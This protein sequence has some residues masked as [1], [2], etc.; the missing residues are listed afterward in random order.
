MTI[1]TTTTLFD[2]ANGIS[3]AYVYEGTYPSGTLV[4]SAPTSTTPSATLDV[5]I[6]G[7]SFAY[8]DP[9]ESFYVLFDLSD[10]NDM[11][12]DTLSAQLDSMVVS[13]GSSSSYT[14][15]PQPASATTTTKTIEGI[16]IT[17]VNTTGGATTRGSLIKMLEIDLTTGGESMSGLTF[18]IG[19]SSG[20]FT[21]SNL[22]AVNLYDTDPTTV[23]TPTPIAQATTFSSSSSVDLEVPGTVA[24]GSHVYYVAYK[25]QSSAPSGVLTFKAKVT[26]VE[27]TGA[28]SAE[29]TVPTANIPTDEATATLGSSLHHFSFVHDT[30]ATINADSSVTITAKDSSGTTITSYSGTVTISSSS[31]VTWKT[32]GG[33]IIGTGSI[34]ATLASGTLTLILNDSA[35]EGITVTVTDSSLSPP[36]S[37]NFTMTISNPVANFLLVPSSTAPALGGEVALAI[38]AR[39]SSNVPITT[40]DASGVTLTAYKADGTTPITTNLH[41]RG[42]GITDSGAGVATITGTAWSGGSITAYVSYSVA[43]EGVIIKAS[44][45]AT[46]T[47]MTGTSPVITWQGGPAGATI[48]LTPDPKTIPP[49]GATVSIIT[50]DIMHDSSGFPIPDH[51]QFTVATTLGTIT[52]TDV[53]PAISGIQIES[54]SGRIVIHL[55]APSGTTGSAVVTAEAVSGSP[56]G[57]TR[58][59]ISNLKVLSVSSTASLV[60]RLDTGLPL[61][62]TVQNIGAAATMADLT[63]AFYAG[64]I[65]GS[66]VSGEYSAAP[67]FTVPVSLSAGETRTFNFTIAAPNLRTNGEIILD[68]ILE[69]SGDPNLYK[70]WKE[71]AVADWHAFAET[72]DSWT[73]TGGITYIVDAPSYIARMTTSNSTG[74]VNFTSGDAVLPNSSLNIYFF[75]GGYNIDL[76]TGPV[77]ITRGGVTLTAGS[78]YQYYSDEGR[79]T[80]RDMGTASGTLV[81]NNVKD[82][83]G[84]VLNATGGDQIQYVISAGLFVGQ[85]LCYPNPATAGS[86]VKIGWE[87]TK[88]ATV[89]VYLY[90]ST[91]ELLWQKKVEAQSGYNEVTW[92]GSDD[93]GRVL[94]GGIYALRLLATDSEGNTYLAR[95]KLGIF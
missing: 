92:E 39:D 79:L 89:R 41:Y 84:M 55:R 25:I 21:T 56:Q 4:G 77:A 59:F 49:D 16:D 38:T 80:I 40:Y 90:N 17:D 26:A 73:A 46:P 29:I 87:Q 3:A 67:G 62:I 53:N 71:Q 34:S 48:V 32:S 68:A 27:A 22:E 88:D 13:G 81:L 35:A 65:S 9:S 69:V 1:K 63:P 58:V 82:L 72:T 64:L 12:G 37:S 83:S 70:R 75:N 52:D 5:P 66:N 14:G 51:T 31:T 76:E 6:S 85:F 10:D 54:D 43:S 7:V 20:T 78:D 30:S 74:T 60:H 95:T 47:P 86:N 24:V 19:N 8:G 50:S 33:A 18:T 42:T 36:I 57:D 94:G 23:P 93:F 28:S 91:G 61:Q 44:D 45:N 2:S 11:I 15:T